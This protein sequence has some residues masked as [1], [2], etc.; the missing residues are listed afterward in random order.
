[1]VSVSRHVEK[2]MCEEA[3]CELSAV[4][5]VQI[6]GGIIESKDDVTIELCEECASEFENVPAAHLFKIDYDERKRVNKRIRYLVE[7]AKEHQDESKEDIVKHFEEGEQAASEQIEDTEALAAIA[8]L[9]YAQWLMEDQLLS[10][11]SAAEQ[12]GIYEYEA[13]GKSTPSDL[14]LIALHQT[15]HGPDS[16]N[17]N[18]AI[19]LIKKGNWVPY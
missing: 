5:I 12:A 9:R 17:F 8:L 19:G 10:W 3:T 18:D 13:R 14:A 7:T 4:Y 1:M 6:D 16:Q 2:T 15:S 11:V